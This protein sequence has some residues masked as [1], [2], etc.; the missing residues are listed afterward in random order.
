[1]WRH[2]KIFKKK[3]REKIETHRQ[4]TKLKIKLLY[5]IYKIRMN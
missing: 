3:N 5:K 1:M 2:I 4:N